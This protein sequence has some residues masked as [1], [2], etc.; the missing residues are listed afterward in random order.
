MKYLKVFTDFQEDMAELEYDEIGRLFL[1]ML[2]YADTAELPEFEGNERFVW[3]IAKRY[4]DMARAA[5]EK[6]VSSA[7]KARNANTQYVGIEAVNDVFANAFKA[8]F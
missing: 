4:I 3:P 5:Y 7:K 8:D 2:R 1:A 6:Q